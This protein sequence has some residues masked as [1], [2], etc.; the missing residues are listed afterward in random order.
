MDST[1]LIL[2]P[3]ALFFVRVIGDGN[4]RTFTKPNGQKP[5]FISFD[6]T[7]GEVEIN[8]DVS[9]PFFTIP[10]NHVSESGEVLPLLNVNTR[11][12]SVAGVLTAILTFMVPLLSKPGSGMQYRSLDSQWL[13]VGDTINEIVF[14]NRYI[15]PC[16]QRIV[17]T[18]VSE[19]SH[20]DNPTSTD[21]IIDGLSSHKWFKEYTNGTVL[22]EAIRT[23]REGYQDCARVYKE[24]FV[25]PKILKNMMAQFGVI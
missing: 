13:Q 14:S 22:Q 11:G 20:S 12:L 16:V 19:A 9:V 1:A 15:T 7:G 18:V 6:T 2:L 8:W 4:A 5:Q 17:C 24:C 10:L 3:F 23:G 25:T 21:K